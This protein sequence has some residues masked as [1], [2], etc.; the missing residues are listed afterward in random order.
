MRKKDEDM[1]S[2]EERYKMYLEKA[3]SVSI[4]VYDIS[5]FI[6]DMRSFLTPNSIV[7]KGVV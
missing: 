2:M 4:V 7:F 5:R 6:S 3:R 1:K